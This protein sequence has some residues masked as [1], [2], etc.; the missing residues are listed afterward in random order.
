MM[1]DIAMRTKSCIYHQYELTQCNTD[2]CM[3]EYD[4]TPKGSQTVRQA[5]RMQYY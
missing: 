2:V 3:V 4:N 5:G 1:Y